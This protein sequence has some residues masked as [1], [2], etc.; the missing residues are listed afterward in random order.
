M[1]YL[2]LFCILFVATACPTKK[3]TL[4]CIMK[5]D[6]DANGEISADEVFSVCD[7]K[8]YWYEKLVYS[9]KW[10]TNKFK[11]DCGFPLTAAAFK[12]KT[13]FKKCSYRASIVHKLCP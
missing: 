1:K 2:I 9:P 3:Q 6:M 5:Y 12:K 11:E 10:I 4:E 13:C 8:M 7:A